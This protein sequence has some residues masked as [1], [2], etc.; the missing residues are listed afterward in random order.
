MTLTF[1]EFVYT[2]LLKPKP[3]RLESPDVFFVPGEPRIRRIFQRDAAGHITGFVERRESWD[4]LWKRADRA[5]PRRGS[6]LAGEAPTVPTSE[7]R[8]RRSC[9]AGGCPVTGPCSGSS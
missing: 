6:C 2:V 4:I 8:V 3:L 9:G 1:P 5:S 7:V